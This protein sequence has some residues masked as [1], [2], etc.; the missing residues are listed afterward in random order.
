[1]VPAKPDA[2]ARSSD[3]ARGCG[4][5]RCSDCSNALDLRRK[6]NQFGWKCDD[7]LGR[8]A[9]RYRRL[10][11]ASDHQEIARE[12]AEVLNRLIRSGAWEEAPAMEDLLPDA[13]MPEK[14]YRY[15]V[16]E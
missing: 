7:Q 8:L 14:F 4:L 15:W 9:M 10:G 13:E 1:M 16:R 2:Q 11:N 12:Y 3:G 6:A 5:L